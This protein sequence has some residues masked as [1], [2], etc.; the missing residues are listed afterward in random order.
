MRSTFGGAFYRPEACFGAA[1][2]KQVKRTKPFWVAHKP[3][4]LFLPMFLLSHFIQTLFA[5]LTADLG[6]RFF[7]LRIPAGPFFRT[8]ET[9]STSDS[10]FEV[11]MF[12]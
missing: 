8:R 7:S 11:P 2:P 1:K 6:I 4:F 3:T 9:G 5:G 10:P 12:M